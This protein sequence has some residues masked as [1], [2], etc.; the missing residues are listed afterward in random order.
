MIKGGKKNYSF[1]KMSKEF[2]KIMAE[3]IS[4]LGRGIQRAIQENI[5]KGVDIDGNSF[6]SLSPDST[7]PIRNAGGYGSKPLI[8]TGGREKGLRQTKFTPASSKNLKFKIEM[9]AKN[10]SE[11]VVYGRKV[12]RKASG[13]HYGAFHNQGYITDSDSMIPNKKVPARKWF[14]IPKSAQPKGEHYKK[15]M[16]ELKLRLRA[17]LKAIWHK[18]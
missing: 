17:S 6:D 4:S 10:K 2:P 18:G 1:A 9:V 15:A 13:L 3:G 14:G 5:E 7:I 11:D 12:K 8:K 16:L